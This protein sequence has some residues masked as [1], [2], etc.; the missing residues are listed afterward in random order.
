M[1]YRS[2]TTFLHDPEAPMDAF[3]LAIAA[4]R[5]WGAHLHVICVGIDPTEPGFY[6]A[7]AQA[8][9]VDHNLNIAREAALALE[10]RIRKRL[11]TEVIG[12]EVE[13]ATVMAGSVYDFL[14]ERARISDLM[15]LP[16]PYGEARG[17]IDVAAVEA[18]LFAASLP[19]LVV[20]DGYSGPIRPKRVLI[21][22][23][24]TQ[25]ALT[26]THD[27]LPLL[28]GTDVDITIIDP[29]QH[30]PD[31]SDPGGRLAQYLNRHGAKAEI[32]ILAKSQPG[33]ADMLC[34]RADERGCD[35]IVMG[36]YGHSRWRESIM[37]GATR[38]MLEIANMPVLMAH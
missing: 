24:E 34:R 19:V 30:G 38:H 13:V 20:P 4:S 3:E 21:G 10:T 27:A 14:A 5:E 8:I 18:C 23:N 9:T 1:T 33:V 2:I 17:Y 28:E 12:W 37:G 25:Q 26:A 7:G 32:S 6:Y 29:L 16:T 31:R 11:E 35:M 15:I 22:W 36:A